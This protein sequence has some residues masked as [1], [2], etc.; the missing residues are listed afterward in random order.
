MPSATVSATILPAL[1]PVLLECPRKLQMELLQRVYCTNDLSTIGAF[2]KD[3]GGTDS[4]DYPAG[5][6]STQSALSTFCERQGKGDLSV[7]TLHQLY[8]KC[9]P[10]SSRSNP[11]YIQNLNLCTLSILMHACAHKRVYE[12]LIRRT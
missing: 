6:M 12:P 3:F 7:L 1:L 11:S 5:W 2:S 10:R 8:L 4:T 9:R